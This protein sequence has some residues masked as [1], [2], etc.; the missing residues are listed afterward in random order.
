MQLIASS[1]LIRPHGTICALGRG[2]PTLSL[3]NWWMA[4]LSWPQWSFLRSVYYSP[5]GPEHVA[6]GEDM[7]KMESVC[8]HSYEGGMLPRGGLPG[9]LEEAVQ[10]EKL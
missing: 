5:R 9:L 8:Q 7:H 2:D 6:P 3:T 1:P 4:N 10:K